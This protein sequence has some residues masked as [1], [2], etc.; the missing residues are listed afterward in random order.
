MKETKRDLLVL[1]RSLIANEKAFEHE[2]SCLHKILL[3]V[4]KMNHFCIANEVVDVNR[5]K[6]I[7]KPFLVEQAVHQ[8]KNKPFVFINCKN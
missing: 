4:E 2:V 8:R 5:Y 6:V 3:E 7:S 1:S